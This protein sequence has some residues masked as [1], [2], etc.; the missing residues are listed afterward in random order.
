[1]ARSLLSVVVNANTESLPPTSVPRWRAL[2]W[3]S[4]PS[5]PRT[6]RSACGSFTL[7][8]PWF[9]LKLRQ[10]GPLILQ[11]ISG[12]IKKSSLRRLKNQSETV[13]DSGAEVLAGCLPV[14]ILFPGGSWWQLQGGRSHLVGSCQPFKWNDFTC[15]QLLRSNIHEHWLVVWN[16]FFSFPYIGNNHPNWRT[17]IFSEG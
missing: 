2:E 7:C 4:E 6:I 17:H 14:V 10:L 9:S 11:E 13:V 12:H 5:E 3:W 16:I 8:W 15:V 1:M